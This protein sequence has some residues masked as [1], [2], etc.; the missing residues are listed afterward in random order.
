MEEICY[1]SSNHTFYSSMST[2][3][4]WTGFVPVRGLISNGAAIIHKFQNIVLTIKADSR[5]PESI[6]SEL[7]PVVYKDEHAELAKKFRVLGS[8]CRGYS[9]FHQGGRHIPVPICTCRLKACKLVAIQ[10]LLCCQAYQVIIF[11]RHK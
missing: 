6:K 5:Q 3:K 7:Q 2:V 11:S 8:A 9:K 1:N 10:G 4:K